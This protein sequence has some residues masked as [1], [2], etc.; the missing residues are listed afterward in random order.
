[1]MATPTGELTV[2]KGKNLILTIIL[3]AFRTKQP[4][5]LAP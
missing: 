4:L 5:S 2:R 3:A 1:M